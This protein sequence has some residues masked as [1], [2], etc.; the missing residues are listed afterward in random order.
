MLF[1]FFV[2][3]GEMPIGC[4]SWHCR[5]IHWRFDWGMRDCICICANTGRSDPFGMSIRQW[6]HKCNVHRHVYEAFPTECRHQLAGMT[7]WALTWEHLS[8][9]EW[10]LRSG[11]PRKRKLHELYTVLCCTVQ[12]PSDTG[13]IS[14]DNMANMFPA[15]VLAIL[16][17]LEMSADGSSLDFSLLRREMLGEVLEAGSER[18]EWRRVVINK[19]CRWDIVNWFPWQV[20]PPSF[21]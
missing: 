3:F 2:A 14:S 6:C 18:Y 5:Y 21:V 20:L 10:T 16:T 1:I 17:M 4:V 9:E 13:S 7:W 8:Q 11:H 12:H 19:A 15:V